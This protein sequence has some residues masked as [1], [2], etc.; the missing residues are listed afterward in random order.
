MFTSFDSHGLTWSLLLWSLIAFGSARPPDAL[1]LAFPLTSWSCILNFTLDLFIALVCQSWLVDFCL[2]LNWLLFLVPLGQLM[3][4]T[5]LY[6]WPFMIDLSHVTWSSI[7]LL[8]LFLGLLLTCPLVPL[9][10]LWL[11][12]SSL[13]GEREGSGECWICIQP[14]HSP[15]LPW[16]PLKLVELCI[17][18][19][20]FPSG[21]SHPWGDDPPPGTLFRYH[22]HCVWLKA[23]GPWQSGGKRR[24]RSGGRFR[25]L[26]PPPQ[27]AGVEGASALFTIPACKLLRFFPSLLVL[28]RPFPFWSPEWLIANL[29]GQTCVFC[30][31][32]LLPSWE[33]IPW[34]SGSDNTH[35]SFFGGIALSI[36]RPFRYTEHV[37]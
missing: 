32:S 26:K 19:P 15:S 30:I 2:T 35:M 5:Q 4:W 11:V 25:L 22:L 34:L 36:A 20:W 16:I 28:V 31:R 33:S 8:D 10:A 27:A 29:L 23:Q 1:H 3:S 37:K 9:L 6:Q 13:W 7:P 24:K 21:G 14:P 17:L 12:S 18:N